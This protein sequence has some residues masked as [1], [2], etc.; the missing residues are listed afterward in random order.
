MTRKNAGP[1][2][3]QV[4]NARLRAPPKG[5][6]NLL[7]GQLCATTKRLSQ[8]DCA[9]MAGVHLETWRRWEQCGIRNRASIA[10]FNRFLELTRDD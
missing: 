9:A 7:N 6:V 1:T 5:R 4:L 8:R 3:A 10:A 2:P